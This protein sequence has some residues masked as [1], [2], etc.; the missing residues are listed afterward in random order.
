MIIFIVILIIFTIIINIFVIFSLMYIWSESLRL[1]QDAVIAEALLGPYTH[2]NGSA[3]SVLEQ[4]IM[5]L[6]IQ[7]MRTLGAHEVGHTLGGYVRDFVR[8]YRLIGGWE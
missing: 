8:G 3:D 1:R 6:L 7:R 5:S 4:R 2:P